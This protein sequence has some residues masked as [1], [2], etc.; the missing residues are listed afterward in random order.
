MMVAGEGLG[1]FFL[2]EREGLK[3]KFWHYTI[4]QTLQKI[5]ETGEIKKNIPHIEDSPVVCVSSN[6]F[7][8]ETVRKAIRDPKTGEMTDPLSRDELFK[9]GYTP[10]R[11]EMNMEIVILHSWVEHHKKKGH[12]TKELAESLENK[13]IEWGANPNQWWVSYQSIPLSDCLRP[14][15]IWNG[16]GWEAIKPMK[17]NA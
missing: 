2:F 7:W 10:V 3:M 17:L 14:D 15:E 12:I 1:T 11:I 16:R 6:S 9:K 13:G 5:I 4:S 8:E